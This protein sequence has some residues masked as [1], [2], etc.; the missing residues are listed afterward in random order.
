MYYLI[1]S[2]SNIHVDALK[3]GNSSNTT[4]DNNNNNEGRD[5]DLSVGLISKYI[6]IGSFINILFVS[7]YSICIYKSIHIILTTII[8]YM[9]YNYIYNILY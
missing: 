5:Y 8:H 7:F 2:S 6:D 3:I 4:K 9:L 1:D